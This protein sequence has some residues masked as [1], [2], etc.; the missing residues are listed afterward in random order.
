[1]G[2]DVAEQRRLPVQVTM[3]L[4]A[5]ITQESLDEDYRHVAERGR[6]R[7]PAAESRSRQWNFTVVAVVAFGLLVAIAAVQTSRTAPI[8][9]ASK[10]VLI[11]RIDD[12][13]AAVAALHRRIAALTDEN[14]TGDARYSNLGRRLNQARTRESAL[15]RST[16]FAPVSG[17]GVRV[18]VDDAP[19]A[20]ASNGELVQDRDLRTLFD[21]LWAAGATAIAVNGQRVTPLSAPRNTGAV[22]RINSTSLSPPY[23]VL[24]LGD[25]KT[26]QAQ[27][28]ATSS[29]SRF[30]DV[31]AQLGMPVTMDNV[32]H[33]DLPAA[34]PAMM[35]LSHARRLTT[36]KPQTPQE[37]VS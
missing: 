37:D 34:R 11:Q 16:G 10:E 32:G 22:I 5:R 6:T 27:F 12:Q 3:P 7:A 28:A 2:A 29:G 26:L 17:A 33:L 13:Q 9:V 30:L 25:I 15:A 24:A 23:R 14:T 35:R 4:L 18:T 1:V 20:T 8:R 19:G 36:T 21:G 31:V